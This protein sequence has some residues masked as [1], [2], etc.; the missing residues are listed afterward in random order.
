MSYIFFEV[1]I[2]FSCQCLSS[3]FSQ[4]RRGSTSLYCHLGTDLLVSHLTKPSSLSYLPLYHQIL[5]FKVQLCHL[6]FQTFNHSLSCR[7][8]SAPELWFGLHSPWLP[9]TRMWPFPE[10][11]KKSHTHTHT[12]THTSWNWGTSSRTPTYP[13]EFNSGTSSGLVALLLYS[14][15]NGMAQCVYPA[16][17][18]AL[19]ASVRL[20]FSLLDHQC[21]ALCLLQN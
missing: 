15:Y 5:S 17:Q 12:H 9:I 2:A 21:L 13:S 18:R 6:L 8:I 11:K 3:L 10:K 4:P 16:L 19:L 20:S 7:N 1:N 14:P